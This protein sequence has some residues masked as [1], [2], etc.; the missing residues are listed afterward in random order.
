MK[1]VIQLVI[2]VLFLMMVNQVSA[3]PDKIE[4]SNTAHPELKRG[5]VQNSVEKYLAIESLSL[6]ISLDKSLHGFVEGKI[7]D[8]CKKVTV[9]ITPQTKAYSNNIEVP[10]KQAENRLGRYATVIYE[11]K[12]KQVIAIRW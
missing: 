8:A 1:T 3:A 10:L 9:T 2:S 6:R 11:V 12:T 5:P 7:C 4:L